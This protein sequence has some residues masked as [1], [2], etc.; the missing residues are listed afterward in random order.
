MRDEWRVLSSQT[1]GV[2]FSSKIVHI[3]DRKSASLSNRKRIKLQLWDTA[4]TERF[5]SVSRSYYRG[6]AGAILVYDVSSWRSFEQ[7]QTFLNDARARWLAQ[8]SPSYWRGTRTTS[9]KGE[10]R[11]QVLDTATPAHR[12]RTMVYRR[13]RPRASRPS[14]TIATTATV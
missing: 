9:S 1:I 14:A 5:R 8:T 10:H 2:E 12:A 3:T 4:G 11:R 13:P 6:A 7:L